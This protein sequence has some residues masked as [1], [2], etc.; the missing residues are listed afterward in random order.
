M[1][2]GIHLKKDALKLLIL[3]ILVIILEILP[4][5]VILKFGVQLE[6]GSI[7]TVRDTFSYFSMTPFGYGKFSPLVTAILSCV[8]LIF[9]FIYTLT[10]RCA[11]GIKAV[12]VM[13]FIVSL[14]P[15]MFNIGSSFSV[16]GVIISFVL[17][18]EIF[19]TGKFL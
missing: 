15:L 1:N 2:K 3:P 12:S 4:Y 5:G 14:L 10:Q 8:L 11:I 6:D 18:L 17:G 9:T 13:V 7:G 16:L 19:F